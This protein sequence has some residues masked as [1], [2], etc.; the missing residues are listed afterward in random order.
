MA[1]LGLTCSMQDLHHFMWDLPLQH[2]SSP[3]VTVGSVVMAHRIQSVWASQVAAHGLSSCGMWDHLL[4]SMWDLSS[5]TRDLTRNLHC[6]VGSYPLDHQFSSV[7]QLCLTL[8][9][10]MDYST[11]GFP[12]RH[13]LL[14][15]AQTHVHPVSDAIQSSH[16]LSSPAPPAFNLSQHQSFP[17]SQLFTSGGQSIGVSVSASA[18]PMNSQD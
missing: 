17:V 2:T 15:V 10:P 18:L 7:A 9:D 11:P 3:D 16:P 14:E 5:L 1:T 6:T 8:C 4:H 12:V 13:Q